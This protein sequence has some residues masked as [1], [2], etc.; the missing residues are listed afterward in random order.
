MNKVKHLPHR[1]GITGP[2]GSGKSTLVNQLIKF[3]RQENKRVAV[4]LVDPTSPFTNGSVLGDRIRVDS[5]HDDEN[6]FIRS[7]PSRNST[8]GLSHNISEISD[9]L[10]SASFDVIL[11]ETVGVGQVE[12]DVVKEV[13]SVILTLVPESGDDIQMMKAGILEIAD[14]Y[15]INKYDRKDS[16]RL[17]R[18]LKNMLSINEKKYLQ[19]EWQPVILKTVATKGEGVKELFDI[20]NVHKNHFDNYG[21][22]SKHEIR[23]KNKIR[24][25]LAEYFNDQF[26]TR[27]KQVKLDKELNKG[28]LNQLNP[29]KF[30][31]TLLEDE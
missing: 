6:V 19:N 3:F 15:V 27:E 14:I 30:L 24:K 12:I 5:Y 28:Y 26:W 4:L 21:N 16:N 10:E 2:P 29:Y 23:Y 11:Y 8:G 13:D 9:I 1:I 20:I 31:K 25:L 7:V 22:S 18:S 17:Y